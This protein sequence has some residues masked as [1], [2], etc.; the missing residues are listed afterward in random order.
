VLLGEFSEGSPCHDFGGA[1]L[2]TDGQSRE[3]ATPTAR[4][5]SP[6]AGP[7]LDGSAA[8]AIIAPSS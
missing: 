5:P 7:D 4:T 8:R 3:G 1:L 6:V 2:V